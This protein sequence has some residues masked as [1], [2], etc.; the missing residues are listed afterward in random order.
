MDPEKFH[1][2]YFVYLKFGYWQ[3]NDL[4]SQKLNNFIEQMMK[5]DVECQNGD[6]KNLK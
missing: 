1:L 3:H 4:N 5:R 6:E 2:Q